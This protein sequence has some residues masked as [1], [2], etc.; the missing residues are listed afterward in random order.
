[1]EKTELKLETRNQSIL[2]ME[3]TSN[4]DELI[5]SFSS[6]EP[7]ERFFGKEVL[8][9]DVDNI[10]F[11][12]LHNGGL[13]LFN[14]DPNK[15]LGRVN[16]A[17]IDG[18]K[19]RASIKWASNPLAQQVRKDTENGIYQSISVGYQIKDLEEQ[20]DGS[21]RATSWTPHEV[22]IV[23]IPADPTI[24]IGRSIQSTT[25]KTMTQQNHVEPINTFHDEFTRESDRFREIKSTY[26]HLP[27][28]LKINAKRINNFRPFLLLGASTD[29]NLSSNEN[30]SDDN[31]SNVFRTTTRSFNYE[32]GLGFEFYLYYFKFSPSLRGIFSLQNELIEDTNEES[33]WTK[34][35]INMFSRGV[36]LII[37]FE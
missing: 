21:F 35:I 19:A 25:T 20:E 13:L 14:H 16:D 7:V 32:L 24:G 11:S 34:N 22:S 8:G 10:D 9:H 30:N 1:M 36:S 23:S 29:F 27:L 3:E 5:F 33:P 6:E 31:A 17:W 4:I 12:R 28:Y 2:D 37:T 26:I 15:V 18:R